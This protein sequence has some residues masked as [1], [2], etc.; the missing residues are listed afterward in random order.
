MSIDV[1]KLVWD[2]SQHKETNL[3]AMLALA[4][5][6]NTDGYCWPS[7]DTLANRCRCNRRNIVYVIE[8]LEASGELYVE[9]NR[10]RNKSNSYIITIDIDAATLADRLV[11]YF[12]MPVPEAINE[13]NRH[14]Q[15]CATENNNVQQPAH[16]DNVQ[17]HA[18]FNAENV[19]PDVKNVQ[20]D[21]LK[22]ATA[23]TRSVIEPSYNHQGSDAPAVNGAQQLMDAAKNKAD[24]RKANGGTY[25]NDWQLDLNKKVEAKTRTPLASHLAELFGLSAKMDN[26]DKTLRVMHEQVVTLYQ[27]GYTTAEQMDALFNLWMSDDWRKK[28]LDKLTVYKFTDFAS[29]KKQEEKQREQGRQKKTVRIYNQ[30]T[31]Q[32]EERTVA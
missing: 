8:R 11:K 23:C 24:R 5:M 19:Q 16:L 32:Y 20:P 9:H 10:G 14:I 15:K 27:M 25:F 26:D 1:M 31:G 4:D 2:K 18:R 30:Y 13:A 22:C 17:Q 3:V 7:H 6:A 21:A 28:N 12:D 29:Q